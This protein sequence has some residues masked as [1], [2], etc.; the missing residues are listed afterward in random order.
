[1]RASATLPDVAAIFVVCA[2]VLMGDQDHIAVGV[3]WLMVATAAGV[4]YVN[5]YLRARRAGGNQTTLSIT[6]TLTGT[7]LRLAQIAGSVALTFGNRAGLYVAAVAMVL[8]GANSVSG[9][10]LLLAGVHEETN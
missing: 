1:N 9:A 4:V 5:A 2:L 7:T 6:R 3:E 8:G 10:W